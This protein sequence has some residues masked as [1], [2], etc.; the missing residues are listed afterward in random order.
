MT[1]VNRDPI[2]QARP[3]IHLR[4][5]NYRGLSHRLHNTH[6]SKMHLSL[7]RQFPSMRWELEDE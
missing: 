7:R 2:T 1:D 5:L 3:V 6:I 4:L